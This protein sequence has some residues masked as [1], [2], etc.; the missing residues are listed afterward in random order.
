M[1][2][3]EERENSSLIDTLLQDGQCLL[4]T[5]EA[6]KAAL[7]EGDGDALQGAITLKQQQLSMLASHLAE[8]TALEEL[9]E[10]SD[11][12]VKLCEVL[13]RLR[14]DN[15]SNGY[16]IVLQ[17]QF[18]EDAIA[19]LRGQDSSTGVYGGNAQVPKAQ[20]A[21]PVAKA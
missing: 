16:Q 14:D 20:S 1:Q 8:L 13:Q 19:A 7:R 11:R 10:D 17:R 6:E 5:L 2:H 21:R 4:A 3:T 12:F 9:T 18:A 15:L